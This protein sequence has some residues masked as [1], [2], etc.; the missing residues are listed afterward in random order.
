MSKLINVKIE[1]TDQITVLNCRS[2]KNIVSLRAKSCPRCGDDDPFFF[3]MIS[4]KSKSTNNVYSLTFVV[5]VIGAI[6]LG[7]NTTWWLGVIGGVFGVFISQIIV[8]MIMGGKWEDQYEDL[9]HYMGQHQDP[10]NYQIW[11][12]YA[13]KIKEKA[14]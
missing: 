7:V 11:Y 2:C 5:V 14:D 13:D 9:S 1:D 4:K 8:Y 10:E 3:K 6:I 12:K